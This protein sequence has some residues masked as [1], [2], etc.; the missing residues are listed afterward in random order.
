MLEVILG[1]D[2]VIF[3]SILVEDL[4]ERLQRRVRNLGISLA[5]SE[6]SAKN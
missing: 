4:P 2:N 5:L 3:I 1:V 6:S